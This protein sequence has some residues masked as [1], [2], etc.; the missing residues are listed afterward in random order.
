MTD[1][2]KSIHVEPWLCV[3]DFNEVISNDE[4]CGGA[5]REEWR[6]KLFRDFIFVANLIDIGYQGPSYSWYKMLN[7]DCILK[8]RLDRALLNEQWCD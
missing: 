4:A 1:I 5:L 2:A 7:G 3:R 6:M 8:E